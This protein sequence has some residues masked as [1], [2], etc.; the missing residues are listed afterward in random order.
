VTWE[1]WLD[2]YTDLSMSIPLEQYFV[3]MMESVWGICEDESATVTA[4]QIEFLT[5]TLRH[6][7]LSFSRNQ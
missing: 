2:Y 5:K 3:E 7:L 1:E 6:K 4:S